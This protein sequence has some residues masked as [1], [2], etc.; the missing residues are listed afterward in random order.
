MEAPHIFRARKC[1]KDGA[2]QKPRFLLCELRKAKGEADQ[3]EGPVDLP[4][5]ER[6][7]HGRRTPDLPA[8]LGE[9][10]TDNSPMDCCPGERPSQEG[11]GRYPSA[12]GNAKR[13]GEAQ[14][15]VFQHPAS[16]H[17]SLAQ[18]GGILYR[19]MVLLCI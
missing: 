4:P 5:A 19:F 12:A 1:S 3:E 2:E 16:A 6:V 17:A 13:R 18:R 11:A 15:G 14:Q 10:E 8:Q 9:P 7:R